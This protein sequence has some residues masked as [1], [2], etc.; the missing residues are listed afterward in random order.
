MCKYS[1]RVPKDFKGKF[2][3]KVATNLG[4]FEAKKR[5]SGTRLVEISSKELQ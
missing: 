4:P 5:K 2:H 3:V 1:W